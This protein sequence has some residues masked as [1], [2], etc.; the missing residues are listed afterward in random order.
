MTFLIEG[1][2]LYAMYL[3]YLLSAGY[4]ADIWEDL[5]EYDRIAWDKVANDVNKLIESLQK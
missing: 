1:K 4:G 2:E 3:D 5:E